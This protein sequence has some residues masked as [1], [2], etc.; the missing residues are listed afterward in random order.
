MSEP[1]QILW[2]KRDLRLQDHAALAGAAENGPVL[3][4]YIVE[5]D[6]WRLPDIS[7]RHWH[8][9][10]DS[11][12]DLNHA[13]APLEGALLIRIGD[14]LAVLDD[15]YQRIGAFTLWSH[16]ETGNAWTYERDKQVGAWC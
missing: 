10:H 11:L 5:P 7:R 1:V 9:I 4:L 13:L 14:V 15:L 8:F 16:Q 2:F 6:Y 3:P 12:V